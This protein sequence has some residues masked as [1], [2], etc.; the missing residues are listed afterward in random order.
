M[1]SIVVFYNKYLPEKEKNT[2]KA[3]NHYMISDGDY[4][5]F[6]EQVDKFTEEIKQNY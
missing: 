2:I 1:K 3:S 5:S 6:K 4:E